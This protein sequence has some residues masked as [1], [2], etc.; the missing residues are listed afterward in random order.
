MQRPLDTRLEAA[1]TMKDIEIL[2]KAFLIEVDDC[3]NFLTVNREEFGD[4]LMKELNKGTK[5]EC[6]DLFD[7]IDVTKEGWV[8]WEKFASY[9][10]LEFYEKDDR[11]KSSQVPQWKNL[12]LLASPHKDFVQKIYCNGTKYFTLSKESIVGVWDQDLKLM[13]SSKTV[14]DSC[15]I[16]DLWATSF[17]VM[18]TIN[19]IAISYTSKE[20]MIYDMSKGEFAPQY[21]IQELQHT[22]LYLTF[23]ANPE[24][25]NEAILAWSDTGGNVHALLFQSANIALFERPPAPPGE[26]KQETLLS[27]HLR[28]IVDGKY[29][30]ARYVHHSQHPDWARQVMYSPSLECFIS[31][32][33][34]TNAALVIGWLEK[35]SAGC[36]GH[37][38]DDVSHIARRQRVRLPRAVK[39]YCHGWREQ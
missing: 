30:N 3:E 18:P 16:R 17:A 35:S 12:K 34:S 15:K 33:T 22:A 14:T 7:R 29:R 25:A 10:L 23:W 2:Q 24:N 38:N 26:K 11:I 36:G 32:S 8:D 20:I 37:A 6:E 1:L 4:L 5:E 21:K 13:W 19:K 27:I 28:N 39:S 9:M 31:C